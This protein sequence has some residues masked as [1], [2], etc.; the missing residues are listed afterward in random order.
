MVAAEALVE[1]NT[2]TRTPWA[3]TTA[4]PSGTEHFERG[5]GTQFV[6]IGLFG[7]NRLGHSTVTYRYLHY[8]P[9]F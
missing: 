1:S 7:A 6:Y 2:P 3:A 4:N 9:Y 8:N 5:A